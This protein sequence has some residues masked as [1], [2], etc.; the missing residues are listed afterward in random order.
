M[1][2]NIQRDINYIGKVTRLSLKA[3]TT[4]KLHYGLR[5]KETIM[6]KV[7]THQKQQLKK[8]IN[9]PLII[10]LK[11]KTNKNGICLSTD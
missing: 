4:N 6:Q 11:S 2:M 7:F 8:T 3:K 1:Q 10:L 5:K 9:D